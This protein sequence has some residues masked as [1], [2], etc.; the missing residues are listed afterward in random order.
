MVVEPCD[1]LE[2]QLK[3]HCSNV[4]LIMKNN[5]TDEQ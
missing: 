2:D 3:V 4:D 1:F 5:N